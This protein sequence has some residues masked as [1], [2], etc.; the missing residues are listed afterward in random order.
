V[1]TQDNNV[2]WTPL[3]RATNNFEIVR[4]LI[5]RGANVNIADKN[6]KMPLL[7]AIS[8]K[9]IFN[10]DVVKAIL[11]VVVENIDAKSNTHGKTSLH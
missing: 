4:E 9:K 3:C 7:S 6:G 10:F 2:S 1:N 5:S 8:K 11:G